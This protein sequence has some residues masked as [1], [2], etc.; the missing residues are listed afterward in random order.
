MDDAEGEFSE[1]R[2][3]SKSLRVRGKVCYDAKVVDKKE[4]YPELDT[5]SDLPP[6][7]QVEGI[8]RKDTNDANAGPSSSPECTV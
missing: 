3:K 2:A 6:I 1:G 5:S 7:E 8:V 4:K